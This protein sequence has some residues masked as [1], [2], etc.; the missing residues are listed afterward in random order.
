MRNNWILKHIKTPFNTFGT[1]NQNNNY[2]CEYCGHEITKDER[3]KYTF[4][5]VFLKSKNTP[6]RIGT[7]SICN[8]CASLINFSP[9]IVYLKNRSKQ[10]FNYNEM[11][12]ALKNTKEEKNY[13]DILTGD[14]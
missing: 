2:V 12:I 11:Y 8:K 13:L 6:Y 3:I 4:D 9:N 5:A 7:I 10:K 14:I 1:I